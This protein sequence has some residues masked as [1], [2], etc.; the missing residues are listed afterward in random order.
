MLL[1]FQKKKRKS[2]A[3]KVVS[4]SIVAYLTYTSLYTCGSPFDKSIDKPVICDAIDPIKLDLYA[5]YQSYYYKTKVDPHIRPVV[6][7]GVEF[8]HEYG[9]PAQAKLNEIYRRQIRPTLNDCLIP[10][11]LGY[12]RHVRPIFTKKIAPVIQPY[13]DQAKPHIKHAKSYIDQAH[14]Y[15]QNQ[16]KPLYYQATDKAFQTQKFIQH[17]YDILPPSIKQVEND[18]RNKVMAWVEYAENLEM[19]PILLDLYW[20]IVDFYQLHYLPVLHVNPAVTHIKMFYN[21]NAKAHFDE[22][23]KPLIAQVNNKVHFDVLIQ[24]IISCLPE[25]Q[26][27]PEEPVYTAR[28][29]YTQVKTSSSVVVPKT[30]NVPITPAASIKTVTIS[31]G[32]TTDDAVPAST[33]VVSPTIISKKVNTQATIAKSAS[34]DEDIISKVASSVKPASTTT[35]LV[36]DPEAAPDADKK[37]AIYCPTCNAQEEQLIVANTDKDVAPV[38]TDKHVIAVPTDHDL[39]E[40]HEEE[41][42][43]LPSPPSSPNK[44]FEDSDQVV[45]QAPIPSKKTPTVK[46]EDIVFS[47]QTEVPTEDHIVI[48]APISQTESP[49]VNEDDIVYSIQTEVPTASD[50]PIF[51]IQREESNLEKEHVEDV[52]QKIV[53]EIRHE[54]KK[55]E[56][57][58]EDQIFVPPAIEKEEL[59]LES[60]GERANDDE[61]VFVKIEEPQVKEAVHFE[62]PIVKVE[63]AVQC[64]E[65]IDVVPAAKSDDKFIKQTEEKH[66]PVDKTN[67]ESSFVQV[68]KPVINMKVA[69]QQIQVPV[70]Q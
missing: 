48:Q 27:I 35:R 17:K 43:D 63:E 14:P 3:R 69:K 51:S 13:V 47:I 22:K 30:Q 57:K 67:E 54:A 29:A 42:L 9:V 21:E 53:E 66:M 28:S 44:D 52:D 7:K 25:R 61:P 33:T 11:A 1:F 5:L 46:E 45:I 39:F 62:E 26:V 23:I 4:L 68:D 32:S 40:V 64:E 60:R 65:P 16:I 38:R 41:A 37:E 8:Y 20:S 18:V 49:T 58:K 6:I 10:T 34:G 15:Y 19:A 70:E 50:D 56:F 31:K 12:T 24:H 59:V 55:E 2:R 36:L